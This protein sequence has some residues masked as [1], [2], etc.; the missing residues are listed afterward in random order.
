MSHLNQLAARFRKSEQTFIKGNTVST[1]IAERLWFG[2]STREEVIAL[3][4]APERRTGRPRT[5][6]PATALRLLDTVTFPALL[7]EK[8]ILP[9][10]SHSYCWQTEGWTAG[11]MASLF[12][13]LGSPD[14]DLDE[15]E[16]VVSGR[17][18]DQLFAAEQAWAGDRLVSSWFVREI[19]RGSTVP[20]AL[21]RFVGESRREE[22]LADL[23]ALA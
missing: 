5:D 23:E 10:A 4:L 17:Y 13:W 12:R 3:E 20:E 15:V 22:I 1:E 11:E 16:D 21:A 6:A 18:R 2:L 7:A 8:L 19:G 14:P 9:S